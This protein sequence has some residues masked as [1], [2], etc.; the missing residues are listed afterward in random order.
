MKERKFW[1]LDTYAG[2]E[3]ET[4]DAKVEAKRQTDK[5]TTVCKRLKKKKTELWA[6]GNADSEEEE[7]EEQQ[8]QGNAGSEEGKELHLVASKNVSWFFMR[9]TKRC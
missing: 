8:E 2:T 6:V 5:Q 4:V 7:E 3:R 9:V 1:V